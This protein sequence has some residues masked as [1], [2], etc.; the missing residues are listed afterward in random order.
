MKYYEEEAESELL[1]EK[2]F[3]IGQRVTHTYNRQ[4]ILIL[5]M[6]SDWLVQI[7]DIREGVIW[8]NKEDLKPLFKNVNDL[9]TL[10]RKGD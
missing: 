3:G 6:V 4:P 1:G 7:V 9:E 10:K 2:L 8:V 5:K